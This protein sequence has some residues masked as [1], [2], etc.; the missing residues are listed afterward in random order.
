MKKELITKA[1][2]NLEEKLSKGSDAVNEY[3]DFVSRFHKYSFNNIMLIY[4]QNSNA[5]YVAGYRKWQKMKRQVKK[6]E[7]GISIVVPYIY[8]NEDGTTDV[9]FG[10]GTVFDISQTEGEPLPDEPSWYE[11][12]DIDESLLDKLTTAVRKDDIDIKFDSNLSRKA[13]GLSYPSEKIMVIDKNNSGIEKFGVICHEWA[14]IILHSKHNLE[15]KVVET[16]AESVSYIVCKAFG[17][18]TDTSINYILLT[19]GD[20]ELLK[21]RYTSI[22]NASKHIIDQI[23]SA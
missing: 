13:K 14:H 20:S 3:L 1:L 23:Q 19:G 7:K 10:T 22:L 4:W 17:I 9:R 8:E 21:T 15:H 12:G 11:D 5:T 6:G 18:K 16:E 2:A